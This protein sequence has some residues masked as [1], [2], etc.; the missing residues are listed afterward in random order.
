ML[1]ALRP[2]R[3]N[4]SVMAANQPAKLAML[5]LLPLLL[6][7][8]GVSNSRC[9]TIPDNSTD[10]LSLLDFKRVITGPGGVLSSWNTS[11]P[12]CQW[13]GV[14]CSLKHP[15]RVTV[16]SLGGLLLAGPISPSIGNLTFLETLNL[17]TNSFSGELPPLNRFHKLQRLVLSYN[18]LHGTIPD[19]LTNCTKLKWLDLSGNFLTGEIPLDISLLSNLNVFLLPRN[20]LIGMIPPSVKNMTQLHAVDF[21]D[22]QLTGSIPHELGKSENLTGVILGGNRL[23]GGIPATLFNCSSLQLLDVSF[24]ML[25]Q[26]LPSKITLP[27]LVFLFLNHNNFEGHIPASIGNISELQQL[28]LASNSFTGKVPSSLGNLRMLNDLNLQINRLEANDRQSWEFIERLSNYSNLQLLS[29]NN[30]HFEGT[31]PDSIGKLSNN[32]QVLGLGTNKLSGIIPTSFRNLTGLTKL[33]LSYNNLN[34]PI[35]EWAGNMKNLEGIALDANNFTGSI[36]SSMSNLTKLTV[37][38]LAENGFEGPIAPSLGSLPLLAY[39]NLSYNNL[40]GNI[41]KEIFHPK[42]SMTTCVLSYNKLEGPIPPEITNLGQLTELYLSSNK[43]TGEIPTTLGNCEEL[44]II[45][46]D[47][48][49]LSGNI[50]TTFSNLKSLTQLNLSHNNLSG[51]IPIQLGDLQNLTQLDLSYNDLQGEVPKDGVFGNAKSISLLGNQGLCGGVQ[52]LHLRPCPTASRRKETQY[53]LIR[54][55]IPLFGFMSLIL[56]IYFML[57][58]KMSRTKHIRFPFFEEKLIKVSFSDLAQATQNFSESNLV[59]TGGYGSVYRGKLQKNK[60]DVAVKVLDL[61]MHGAEKSFLSECEALRNI[62][63]RN[64]VPIVTACSTVDTEGK[65][66]KALIYEFM[67]NGNL[68]VWLHHKGDGKASKC[69]NLTQRINIIVNVADALDYLHNDIGSRSIIHCDVKPSN[70]LLDNDMVAHLGDFGIASF[71]RGSDSA[72]VGD[73]NTSSFGVKGTIGYIAPE[74]A[75]GGRASTC[76]DVYSFGIVVL[77]VLTGKRPTD[78]MFENGLNIVSFLEA[79]FRDQI[80]QVIDATLQEE[81]KPFSSN[82]T[83]EREVYHQCLSSSVEVALSCTRQYPTERANMRQAAAKLREIQASYVVGKSKKVLTK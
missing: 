5:S 37:L 44:N 57:T 17:S 32:L 78:P 79:N 62:Q 3:G 39:L 48:N 66:F 21:A 13:E 60:L 35:L 8:F 70:I 75:G 14:N 53:Y 9:S 26:T 65:L 69:L 31:I 1:R 11:I 80:F 4:E 73:P 49:Y 24:N 36:P 2:S 12:H 19:T 68:D 46:M 33:E 42:S 67:T 61:D 54:V 43:L 7:S 52:D 51:F 45:K 56:L 76:G 63:H 22:N 74:Y 81:C 6:L 18:S 77:E 55:L 10:M 82:S 40:Q 41:P 59:G 20:N 16:L 58:E 34:G 38:S 64:L 23:S 25:G 29:L 28:E 72:P 15:G 27:N 47:R 50:S 30:N 83:T 71:Y